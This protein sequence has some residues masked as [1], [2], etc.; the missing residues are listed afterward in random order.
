MY[1]IISPKNRGTLVSSFP[2]S[3]PLISIICL[4]SI[5]KIWST[6]LDRYRESG[7]SCHSSDLSRIGLSFSSFK[8]MLSMGL[9]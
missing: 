5:A 9:L 7:Q 6:N 8:L 2:I 1:I 4:I 3:I